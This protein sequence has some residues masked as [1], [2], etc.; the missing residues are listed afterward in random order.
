MTEALK[1]LFN[2]YKNLPVGVIFFKQKQLFFV[3]DHLRNILTL[4][5]LPGDDVIQIIGSMLSLEN[6]SHLSMYTYLSDNDFFWYRDR[7]MQI[8]R[9]EHDD[10]T[11][12]VIVR[13]NDKSINAVD[14]VHSLRLLREKTVIASNDA[15]S[16]DINLLLK[17]TLGIYE[18]VKIPSI[19]LYKGIP[20]KGHALIRMIDK[21]FVTLEVDKKQL[22]AAQIGAE[23]LF[24]FKRNAMISAT[25]AHYDLSTCTVSLNNLH[26]IARAFHQRNV[27]RYYANNQDEMVIT[28]GGKR[29]QLMLRDVSERAIAIET[30]SSEALIALSHL[31]GKTVAAHITLGSKQISVMVTWLYT[32]AL[33]NEEKRMKAAFQITYDTPNGSLLHEWLNTQQLS[34]IK[35]VHNFVQM[36]PSPTAESAAEWVI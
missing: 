20:I 34:L 30:D 19:V 16:Y 3:N 11:V 4:G 21:E 1:E 14:S 32:V 9:S 36:L 23:W 12:F 22:I 8:E 17:Q 35:E 28:I 5:N 25:L 27:I 15:D 26:S 33:K 29:Y 6:P 2:A 10:I 24:G 13:L 31:E 7:I 18:E